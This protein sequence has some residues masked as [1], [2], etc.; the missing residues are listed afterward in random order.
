[1][2]FRCNTVESFIVKGMLPRSICE[3]ILRF[4]RIPK[5]TDSSI[6]NGT[7]FLPLLIQLDPL[8]LSFG[9]FFKLCM[10]SDNRIGFLTAFSEGTVA[11]GPG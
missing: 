3:K 7:A 4:Q 2:L 6:Y 1:M 10:F 11:K 9:F 8:L 5:S